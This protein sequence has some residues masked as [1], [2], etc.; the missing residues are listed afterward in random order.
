MKVAN[1]ST[2]CPAA[3][4]NSWDI[5]YLVRHVTRTHPLQHNSL[6]KMICTAHSY[7]ISAANTVWFS[8]AALL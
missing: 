8:A 5:I 6:L 2:P 4:L 7:F 1:V 3:A